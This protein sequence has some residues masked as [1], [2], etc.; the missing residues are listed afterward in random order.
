[1]RRVG[2]AIG[3]AIVA[4]YVAPLLGLINSSMPLEVLL[5]GTFVVGGGAQR[6]FAAL[7][8]RT[9]NRAKGAAPSGKP[10]EESSP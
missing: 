4:G 8:D 2:V 1:M 6:I 7:I 3:S 9:A 5:G 10:N